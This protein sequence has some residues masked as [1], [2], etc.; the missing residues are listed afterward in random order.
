M[1]VGGEIYQP[2]RAEDPD[3]DEV[4]YS[5]EGAGAESFEIMASTGYLLTKQLFMEVDNTPLTV[6]IKATDP[7][8]DSGTIKATITP[9]GGKGH[10]VVEGPD[11]IRYPENGTWRVAAYTAQ[12]PRGPVTGWIISVEP[13]GGDG[14]H[15]DIDDDG[16][17]T[18]ISPPDY[19][20]PKD[21]SG[22]NEYTFSIRAYD[23]NPPNGES[24][25]QTFFSVKVIVTNG[26]DPD[27][28]KI[29]GPDRVDYPEDRTDAVATYTVANAGDNPVTWALSGDD[30]DDFSISDGVLTFDTRPDR[31]EPADADTNNVYLV[32]VEASAGGDKVTLPV[33]ITVTAVNEQPTFPDGPGTRSIPENTESGQPIG[34]PVTAN[35]PENDDLKYSLGGKD[36]ESF[37]IDSSTGQLMT[38]DQLD[39]EEK[40]TYTVE[41]LVSEDDG[42]SG[43]KSTKGLRGLRD[44]LGGRGDDS[45]AA[46]STTITIN[47][48]DQNEPPEIT[49][50]TTVDYAEN[51]TADVAT[52]IASDPE[53]VTI[54]WS[55]SGDDAHLFSDSSINDR[56][57]KFIN[58]PDYEAPEDANTDNQYLVTVVASDETITVE[59]EVT[60]TVTDVNEPPAFGEET[61]TRSIAENTGIGTNIGA[62]I[63]ASDPDD[64][65]TLTYTLRGDGAASFAID[66]SSGQLQTAA[67]LDYETKGSYTVTVSV[68]DSKDADGNPDTADDDTIT[69]TI[70]VENVEE[71]GSIQLSSS[72][73]QVDTELIAMLTD[74]DGVD[75]TVT[76][77][78]ESSSDQSTWTA[79]SGETSD[80]YTPV[81]DDESNYLRVTASYTDGEGPGKTAVAAPEDAVRAAP[82]TNVAPAFDPPTASRDVDENTA[83][84][85]NVGD[86]VVATDADNDT[87]TYRLS[88]D[89]ASSF[90]IDSSTGQLK[91]KAALDHETNP[92]YTVTVTASDPSNASD[93]IDVTISVT[94]VAEP[95]PAP[96]TP[97]VEAA[98]TDGHNTLSVSW[99]APDVTGKPDIT[100][101]EVQYQEQ[102]TDGWGTENVEPPGTDTGTSATI[103]GLTPGTTYEVQVRAV[104]ADGAGEWSDPGVGS[105]T[106]VAVAYEQANYSV[107]E[108]QS[109]VITV[110]L[111]PA[112]AKDL[113][114][115]IMVKGG[116]NAEPGDYE[117]SGLTNGV[118]AFAQDDTSQDF[119]IIAKQ[120][121]GWRDETVI[122][123]FGSL[124][125]GVTAG[126]PKTTKVT[127]D[128]DDTRPTS[129]GNTGGG[130]TGGGNTG[131]G[132]TGGSNSGGS[133]S[134]GSASDHDEDDTLV[135]RLDEEPPKESPVEVKDEGGGVKDDDGPAVVVE[136]N[137]APVFT[138]GDQT[139]RRVAEQTATATVIGLPVIATDADG[140]PLTY[141]IGGADG[142]SFA[143]DSGSG[144]L[145]VG[146]SLDFEIKAAYTF[147][148]SVSDGRGGADS[149]VVTIQVTDID[150]VPI[151]N[152]ETQA[153]AVVY[154]D[155]Q[156]T[157]E[158][159]DGVASVTFPVGS[160]DSVYHVRVDSDSNNCAGDS[161]VYQLEVCLTVEIFDSQGNPEPDA[162]L[163]WPAA[164]QMKL[165]ADRLSGTETVLAV[166]QEG[167]VSLW[168]RSA[169]GGEW[170]DL[171]FTLEADDQGVVT[172]TA[173]GIYDSGNFGAV[174][175]P[176]VFE[177]VLR[178]AEP[179]PTPT[180]Q[181][182]AAPT[183]HPT[184]R[185]TPTPAPAPTPTPTPAPTPTARS[186]VT[187]VP[188]PTA[189]PTAAPPTLTPVP[190][191][192]TP[193]TRPAPT[194]TKEPVIVTEE[195]PPAPPP[196]ESGDMPLWPI[197]M[198]IVGAVMSATGG[199]LY[200]LPGRRRSRL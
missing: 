72:Q 57:L 133:N 123:G 117:L 180:P 23:T 18:F 158:T 62:A 82:V 53:G 36:A 59:L 50:L 174:T 2:A 64:G 172:I 51:D 138:E 112:A 122:L 186:T 166:Q 33:T 21:E 104:N 170:M 52:Y 143:I 45:P 125:E 140:D 88:G 91:T 113:E 3:G 169:P 188:L 115:P 4:R 136:V 83:A 80:S 135:T 74:P 84:G 105:T 184:L 161:A 96:G 24:P 168:G 20:N 114:I 134:G 11:E 189:V 19:E 86:P 5:L 194:V 132:N 151:D 193:P 127:I 73:P 35:D 149:I 182:T 15:F 159:P 152:P 31:E 94:D 58:P 128:D 119:T 92:S 48:E 107:D 183:P 56:V 55:L 30:A 116:G 22:N 54:T 32:T 16:V 118:L 69:V 178:P 9:S 150:E 89:N 147:V 81:A 13:G 139:E 165:D 154:P 148:V 126:S 60:V 106:P 176:A 120:D 90:D 43:G 75:S 41:V 101:Y 85:E 27:P 153:V 71:A 29:T 70:Y 124:P 47:V 121:V 68:R 173:F 175:D 155:S 46:D 141:S 28:L 163:D 7:S 129:S 61:A 156:I 1:P 97:T 65:A 66:E 102:G 167:G 130:N 87:L 77:Q 63:T 99:E 100:D 110:T 200:A 79:I 196:E 34:E 197:I 131:G 191:T 42:N 144:Q 39:H 10:P 179:D 192:T 103:S 8:G 198:M 190:P 181:P 98:A 177:R 195:T 142:A 146:S 199:G 171:E 95:P 108:G 162:V 187:P 14:D 76:W 38:K 145:S 37:D 25:G 6:T 109:A 185:P 78:W 157:V 26:E 49:G 160:R 67:A 164:I 17:L 137:R 111:S 44:V 93:S 12:N 40:D